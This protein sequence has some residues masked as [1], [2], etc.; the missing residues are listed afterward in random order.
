MFEQI[1]EMKTLHLF[2]HKI[3]YLLQNAL[4][5]ATSGP[6]I[7]IC[8][9]SCGIFIIDATKVKLLLRNAFARGKGLG[10]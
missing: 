10:R 1:L 2:H 8:L 9:Q 4:N 6:G 3:I 7:A 5:W